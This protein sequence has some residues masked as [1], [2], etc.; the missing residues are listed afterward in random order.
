MKFFGST[1]AGLVRKSNQDGYII[2]FNEAGD[3]FVI[4]CDGIGGSNSGDLAAMTA[5][6]YLSDA[7]SSTQDF[8]TE[9]E[10]LDWLKNALSKCNDEIFSLSAVRLENKGMGTTLVALLVSKFGQYVINMGDSRC[11]GL[12]KN[13]EFRCLTVDHNLFNDLIKSGEMT[14]E[15]ANQNK[16]KNYLT[17]A[18]GVWD[19]IKVDVFKIKDE[20]ELFLLCT[21]GL[22]GYV[23]GKVIENIVKDKKMN[24]QNKNKALLQASLDAGG[25]DNVT[26][27]LVSTEKEEQ[28]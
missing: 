5:I 16:Q 21:D 9:K 7:F 27:V 1:D 19:K 12:F 18:L 20:V 3:V 11:Y 28:G 4:V 24:L 8:D 13:K 10:L 2:A 26:V 15:Q 17:N 14:P 25:Y 22:H 6:Q 23:D